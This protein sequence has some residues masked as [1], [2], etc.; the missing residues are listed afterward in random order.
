MISKISG[1]IEQLQDDTVSISIDIGV[2]YEMYIGIYAIPEIQK[3]IAENEFLELHTYHYLEGNVTSSQMIPRLI[4]FLSKEERD[5]F[6]RFI[7][8]P[9]ISARS[10]IKALSISPDLIADAIANSNLPVLN[11]LPGIGKKKAEQIVSKLQSQ[12]FEEMFKSKIGNKIGT[13]SNQ[14]SN[15]S[16]ATEVLVTQLGYKRSEAE[17]LVIRALEKIDNKASTEDILEEVFRLSN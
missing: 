2:T 3:K 10:G 13:S 5:F 12:E 8:V 4:G 1:K 9:G 15:T 14:N 6:I 17:N 7:K 11:E 16:E